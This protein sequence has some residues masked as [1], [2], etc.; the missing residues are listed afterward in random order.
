M[1]LRIDRNKTFYKGYR[2]EYN[3]CTFIKNKTIIKQQTNQYVHLEMIWYV[4]TKLE[5]LKV[6]PNHQTL[7]W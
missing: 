3:L 5:N 1:E 4:V 7:T 2:N 6:V